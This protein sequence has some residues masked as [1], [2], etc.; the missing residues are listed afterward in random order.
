[1]RSSG[2][3]P[4]LCMAAC[5][6]RRCWVFFYL[7]AS[8][9]VAEMAIGAACSQCRRG[10]LSGLRCDETIN[11]HQQIVVSAAARG[12]PTSL[13]GDVMWI[14]VFEKNTQEILQD[15]RAQGRNACS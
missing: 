1:M 9:I 15:A 14:V 3:F 8:C 4:L 10:I 13:I 5:A 6:P 7:R 12:R 2:V 11:H